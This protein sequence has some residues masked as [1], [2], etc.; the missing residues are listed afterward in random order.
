M[1][2]DI[3]R[4]DGNVVEGPV[5]SYCTGLGP[6]WHSNYIGQQEL[7][8]D[9]GGSIGLRVYTNTRVPASLPTWPQ[10]LSLHP[11]LNE[12]KN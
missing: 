1:Q 3:T 4:S 6:G 11:D 5:I 10:A 12:R 7:I 9:C 8:F 2:T